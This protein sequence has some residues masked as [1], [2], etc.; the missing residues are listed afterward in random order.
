MIVMKNKRNGRN[1]MM[2]KIGK[3]KK[4][5]RKKLISLKEIN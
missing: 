1:K 2:M 5:Y 4:N 3:E